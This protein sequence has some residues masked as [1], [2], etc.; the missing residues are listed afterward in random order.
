TWSAQLD[1][2]YRRTGE[3]CVV[4]DRHS[5]PLRVLA[6][7]YPESAAVCHNVLVHPPGGLVGGDALRI[8]LSLAAHS[9][10]LLT[11]P[12]ATRFYRSQGETASQTLTAHV[13]GGARLEWLP[14]E[15]LCRR[16]AIAENRMSFELE[17]GAEMIGWDV[18]GLGLPAS[19]E[20][21]DRGHVTQ[22]IAV[23]RV[24]L[25]H[26]VVDGGADRRLLDSPLGFAGQRVLGLLWYAA[27]A[28]PDLGKRDALLDAARQASSVH[29]LHATAGSTSPHEQV[30]LLRALAPRVEPLM[31][32]FCAVW[33]AWRPLAWGLPACAP[34]VWR[35]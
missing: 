5:G 16:G 24:W 26:G 6:S 10:A 30:V 22:S 19:G 33:S 11:T 12:G 28:A 35:T 3:R 14:Q 4:Y 32:L 21:F 13:G 15:T 2:D 27:G 29:T 1:L 18:L 7:L 34:R 8:A 17:P 20:D 23:N 31:Q 25:E 9:H